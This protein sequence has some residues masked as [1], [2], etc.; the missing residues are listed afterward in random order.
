MEK[1]DKDYKQRNW[2]IEAEIETEKIESFSHRSIVAVLL[3]V[4]SHYLISSC[5]LSLSLLIRIHWIC[6]LTDAPS[7]SHLS[8][9]W[10]TN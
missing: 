6:W 8:A 4:R 3:Q 7:Y 10:V 5:S 9:G 1:I 2:K